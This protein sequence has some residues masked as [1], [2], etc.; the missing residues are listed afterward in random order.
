MQV[1]NSY[2]RVIL[3][4]C[5]LYTCSD[6][7]D[8]SILT[9]NSRDIGVGFHS[10]SSSCDNKLLTFFLSFDLHGL[11]QALDLD[12][13][14]NQSCQLW[15]NYK[16]PI[17][18]EMDEFMSRFVGSVVSLKIGIVKGQMI[19]AF[20]LNLLFSLFSLLLRMIILVL[21][22]PGAINLF[23]HDDYKAF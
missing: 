15:P 4:N 11:E 14:T 17:R 12:R 3:D 2:I 21:V 13:F 10:Y 18:M 16:Q 1:F 5:P 20:K 8:I 19:K 6:F 9:F 7:D 23:Y 22:F